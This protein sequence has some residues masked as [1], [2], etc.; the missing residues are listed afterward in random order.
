ASHPNRLID[1][2]GLS[3]HKILNLDGR[4]LVYSVTVRITLGRLAM[5]IVDPQYKVQRRIKLFSLALPN[6][7]PCK[8]FL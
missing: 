1:D 4:S 3:P 5:G 7:E 8:V 6:Q 2:R